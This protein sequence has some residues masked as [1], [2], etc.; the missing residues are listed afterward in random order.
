LPA[1]LLEE[2][3][4]EIDENKGI[5]D[6]R[7][8][9]QSGYLT[10]VASPE[11]IEEAHSEEVQKVLDA[12]KPDLINPMVG[13]FLAIVE[14]NRTHRQ[15]EGID[16]ALIDCE[17]RVQSKYSDTKLRSIRDFGGSEIY[18]GLTGV[19]ARAADAWIK[20]ILTTDR[21]Q[22]WRIEP[23]PVVDIPKPL[24]RQMAETA[25]QHIKRLQADAEQAGQPLELTPDIIYDLSATVRDKVLE[26]R[27]R[28]AGEAAGRM[29]QIIHDQMVEMDFEAVFRQIITDICNSKAG[30]LKG[31]I[32]VRKK[33]RSWTVDE[34]G[35]PTMEIVEKILPEVLR[36]DP[37]N[38]FP[39]PVTNDPSKGNTAERVSFE[40]NELADLVGQPGYREEGISN[41]L[42]NFNHTQKALQYSSKSDDLKHVNYDNEITVRTVCTGWEVWAM[43]PG[44]DLIDFGIN[45]ERDDKTPIDP[46]RSYDMNAIII[47]SELIYLAHNPSEFGERPYSAAGWNQITGS[48]WN[49]SIAELMS[50]LQDI[51]NGSARALSNNMAFSSGPQTVINDIE[52]LPDG[53]QL[54]NPFPLKM[55]Q[56]TNRGKTSGKPLDFFQPNS[57]AS[58]LLAVYDR[59]AKL[60]DDFTG[61]PAYAYGNDRVAGAGRTASGLSMLMSSAARGV[62]NVILRI[63]EKILRKVVRDLYYYNLKYSNDPVLAHG[64]DVNVRATGAIQ[65]MIKE[66]M[67]ARRLEFLQAT[68]N[69]IDFKV[70]GEENRARLLRDIASTLDLDFDPVKTQE[71]IEAMIQQEAQQAA[72]QRNVALAEMQREAQKDEAEIALKAAETAL[73]YAEAQAKQNLE[74]E[75]LSQGE[76]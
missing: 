47:D 63:D 73:K 51:C 27:K 1:H 34:Q 71:Q 40:R 67:A 20:E 76:A 33:C 7:V 32:P 37:D 4:A 22:L 23:T 69:D 43:T 50:D 53:E 8:P 48:F 56:F 46:N 36:V 54:T 28:K 44:Q 29:E 61:I 26:D 16:D 72:E 35:K 30:I 2:K 6:I 21:E 24:A 12:D 10:Q 17:E 15:T 19:K 52:R 74:Q 18:M 11:D 59:F 62:K 3:M 65:V 45:V 64:A 60:A 14:E 25:V 41:I 49:T 39:S 38:F 58:E 13:F 70:V 68:T 9:N 57:N 66:S 5:M 31:P 55:W 42:T 75:K